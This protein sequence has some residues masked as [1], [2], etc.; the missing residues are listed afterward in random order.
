MQAQLQAQK[1]ALNKKPTHFDLEPF[2]KA[3]KSFIAL[4]AESR[5]NL[6]SQ[7]FQNNEM[8]VNCFTDEHEENSFKRCIDIKEISQRLQAHGFPM[9][10]HMADNL[11]ALLI[12]FGD[13]EFEVGYGERVPPETDEQRKAKMLLEMKRADRAKQV[14]PKGDKKIAKQLTIDELEKKKKED[15]EW[16]KEEEKLLLAM[17]PSK[18]MKVLLNLTSIHD[19]LNAIDS[20][21]TYD[22]MLS[23]LRMTEF[24]DFE[25]EDRALEAI[26]KPYQQLLNLLPPIEDQAT[27]S[28]DPEIQRICER[29]GDLDTIP[30]PPESAKNAFAITIFCMEAAVDSRSVDFLK[31]AF[32]LFPD[33]DY[34]IVTQPHTVPENALLSKFTLVPK[35]M[36]N[37]FAH[38]LYLIHR[39]YLLE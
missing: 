25:D 14:D 2:K 10:Q 23:E 5:S 34:L 4:N 11:G 28:S 12:C 39:D 29:I 32:N 38:V 3:L 19:L 36:N 13:I 21:Q 24:E 30:D 15:E 33:R 22:R 18:P 7:F 8:L 26:G 37:T 9:D 35:S 31:Y 1:D 20:M 27:Y 16:A 6:R 17:K